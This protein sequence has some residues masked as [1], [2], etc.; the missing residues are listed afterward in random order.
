MDLEIKLCPVAES[1]KQARNFVRDS[2]VEL[3]FPKGADD[4]ALV[5][6]ELAANAITAAP[7]TPF[8]VALRITNGWP[9]L[10]VQDCSPKLPVMQPA[11]S[12]SEH[13]RGLHIVNELSVTWDT[14]LL[15]SGKVVWALLERG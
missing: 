7:D 10:E 4:A 2:L 5:A 6:D 9:I 13:G 12:T 3:G 1:A 8:W 15:P 11:D 14:I